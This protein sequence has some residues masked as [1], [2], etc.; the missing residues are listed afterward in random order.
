MSP[1]KKIKTWLPL[2]IGLSIALGIF[3]GSIY[4]QFGSIGKVEGTGKIDAVFNYI[5]KSYVDTVNMYQL[6]EEALPKIVHELDP[7]SA[8][9]PASEIE[10]Y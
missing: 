4:S 7:H 10:T 8:Y 5:N 2:W 9:I 3:I 6:V 1:E